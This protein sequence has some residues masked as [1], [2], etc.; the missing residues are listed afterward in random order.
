[1]QY[2]HFLTPH[3]V[4]QRVL[5]RAMK[6]PPFIAIGL[7]AAYEHSPA[8][9]VVLAIAVGL[10]LAF[11]DRLDKIATRKASPVRIAH[12]AGDGG[13]FPGAQSMPATPPEHHAV[14]IDGGSLEH[15]HHA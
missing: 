9:L 7:L 2:S 10:S 4:E 5:I 12:V 15:R 8:L 3:T 6:Y 13:S 1:M 14:V 11:Q